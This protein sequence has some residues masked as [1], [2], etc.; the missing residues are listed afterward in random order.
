[1]TQ[2]VRRP[3]RD[4]A[5]YLADQRLQVLGERA[6]ARAKALGAGRFFAGFVVA[7]A[8]PALRAHSPI[9]LVGVLGVSIS[10][11]G[12]IATRNNV[13]SRVQQEFET[14]A[15]NYT[16]IVTKAIDRYLEVI[17]SVGAFMV[18]S[19]KVDRWEFFSLVEK[20]LPRYPGIQALEWVPRVP[21]E[22]RQHYEKLA[23]ADGLYG[24]Q[25]SE[26][27]AEGNL[28]AA[29]ARDEYFPVFYVEPFE[30]NQAVL[31]FD[32]SSSAKGREALSLARDTGQMV[33]TQR[34]DLRHDAGRRGGLLT[35]LPIYAS[36]AVPGSIDERRENLAGFVLG[37]FRIGDMI[38]AALR[39]LPTPAGLDI[40]LYDDAVST[41]EDNLLHYH[42]SLLRPDRAQAKPA[43]GVHDGLF[44]STP[45]DVAGRQWSIVVKP[46]AGYFSGGAT[47]V[48]WNVAAVGLFL[49][50]LLLQ[51]MAASRNRT[52]V[53]ERSVAERT[54]EL[55]E[56]NVALESEMQERARAEAERMELERELLQIQKMESLGTLAGGIAHEINTPVQYVGEN[57]RFLQESFLDLGNVLQHYESLVEAAAR[58]AALSQAVADAT[59]TAEAA[60]MAFL[61][62]EIP[63]SID[64]S[65]EGIERI[66]EI[67]KAIKE[68]SHPDAKEKTAID[69]NH[70]IE[71]TI[72]VARNQWKYVA[73]LETDFDDT[74][75]H[76][77]C[78]P[79]EL[80]QV[81][82][83]LIVNAAHA[84]EDVGSDEKG[85]ITVSTRKFDD[86]V[87]I[88]VRDTG[89]GIPLENREKIFDPFFTTK[90]PG[91]GTGQG[92]AISHTIITKKHGGTVS[93][94]SEVG[95]GSTFIISLPLKV[96][97][98]PDVAA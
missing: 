92:L 96:D 43:A 91:K 29:G 52:R 54:A 34:A 74:L 50:A 33:A 71:T 28:V 44:S 38:E 31:G 69:I 86:R 10:V 93:L 80:N 35:V 79:G 27:D 59:A 17:N 32:L 72:T 7:R 94:N 41:S 4:L 26:Q 68:F 77:P 16:A 47:W 23:R 49:T 42:P 67:V 66:S 5:R 78:L 81:I 97:C 37:V 6:I 85:R 83:N 14:P 19:K 18:A 57:L 53:I 63:A 24:F 20:S 12:F 2:T 13:Q 88:R 87:E 46:V 65:L 56:A 21:A 30:G 98:A 55:V 22:K 45:Y 40:Y 58:E 76:V 1:M 62:K 9:I 75:P 90:Q 36:G 11:A 39:D 64:Q 82:L 73:E 95:K 8:M 15:A 61:R 48:P 84:I 89:V 25:I 3:F 60:D 51:Y 70:A